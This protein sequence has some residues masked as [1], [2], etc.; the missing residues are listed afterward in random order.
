MAETGATSTPRPHLDATASTHTTL[1]T[2]EGS[3]NVSG[4]LFSPPRLPLGYG[5]VAKSR[6]RNEVQ[7]PF[8]TVAD[9]EGC[10]SVGGV[11]GNI[12]LLIHGVD[13]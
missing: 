7:G 12:G 10:R 3:L 9:M 8:T 2:D 11:G 5:E 13:D 6:E 4:A 1:A